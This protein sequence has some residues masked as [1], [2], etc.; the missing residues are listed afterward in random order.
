M[1]I[2]KVLLYYHTIK[3]LKP[4]QIWHRLKLATLPIRLF[5]F[6]KEVSPQLRNRLREWKQVIVPQ[7]PIV[8]ERPLTFSFLNTQGIVETT[9]DWN[10]PLIDKLWLYNLHYLVVVLSDISP[11][12]KKDIIHQWISQN[13][14]WDGVGW[15]PYPLSLRIVN[16]IKFAFMHNQSNDDEFNSS[17]YFQCLTLER[18][19]EFHLLGNHLFENAKA[20]VFAGLYFETK[21]S[22]RWFKKGISILNQQLKEQIL[23]DGGHF[24]RSPMYHSIILEGILDLYQLTLISNLNEVEMQISLGKLQHEIHEIVPKMLQWMIS[25]NHQ[26]NHIAFFNDSTLGIAPEPRDMLT[27]ATY[28]GFPTPS[29]EKRLSILQNSGFMRVENDD[30]LIIADVGS[31]GPTYIPGH[32][33]AGTL[34]FEISLGGERLFVNQGISTY[35]AN[36]IRKAERRTLAHNTIAINGEDS[37]QIWS[38]FRVAQRARVFDIMHEQ[39]DTKIIFSAAHDGYHRLNPQI[40]HWREWL[41]FDKKI[42]I[43]DRITGKG[44]ASLISSFHL[45]PN[46]FVESR[47]E[48][49]FLL[50]SSQTNSKANLRFDKELDIQ[51]IPYG[52]AQGFNNKQPGWC[53]KIDKS[54]N[55]LPHSLQMEI[56]W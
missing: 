12:L 41:L 52:Y 13:P 20:L 18:K 1:P 29:S 17:L 43:E 10:A 21:D 8:K 27:Y 49:V 25:L 50:K 6:P 42:L 19:L 34:S 36:Q 46:W 40:T 11:L 55:A 45:H 48:N 16:W 28:L 3:Y 39:N 44:S 47:E 2:K 26:D 5:S 23:E 9:Q 35:N 56:G 51:V 4:S 38:S 24:E 37:S 32:A 54:I 33:H 30:V 53:I 31:L 14:M 15:E 7:S 22:K